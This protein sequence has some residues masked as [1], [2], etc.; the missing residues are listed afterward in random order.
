GTGYSSLSYL[1]QLPVS[2]VK[3]D[4][5]FVT[6]VDGSIADP[7]IVEAV[8][9]LAHTL[10][11]RVVA[12]G[13]EELAQAEALIEFDVDE[14]QGY[15][16]ARPLEA[17]AFVRATVGATWW[18]RPPPRNASA[19]AGGGS[20]AMP[21][22]GGPRDRLLMTRAVDAAPVP[23]VVLDRSHGDDGGGPVIHVNP[24]FERMTGFLSSYLRGHALSELLDSS[25]DH[26]HLTQLLQ[27]FAGSLPSVVRVR[28]RSSWGIPIPVE[29]SATPVDDERG[30]SSQW[31]V[32]VR[33]LRAEAR[34]EHRATPTD[35]PDDEPD[36]RRRDRRQRLAIDVAQRGLD[37]GSADAVSQLADVLAEI[38]AE[39]NVD[40]VY[41]DSFDDASGRAV[42]R[43]E[44]VRVGQPR[45][46]G[47]GPDLGRRAAWLDAIKGS[48]VLVVADAH[49]NDAAWL[50]E[51]FEAFETACR[52]MISVPLRVGGRLLGAMSV[53]MIDRP[54]QWDVDEIGFV[55][56]LAQVI[57]NLLDMR[58]MHEERD[59]SRAQLSAVLEY[60]FDGVAM[61]DPDGLISY[62]NRAGGEL[63]G[64]PV[65]QLVGRSPIEFIEPDDL[66]LAHELFAPDA[67]GPTLG[68]V[69]VRRSD[70]AVIWVELSVTR[71]VGGQLE[72]FVINGR[73][74]T[75]RVLAD[76]AF[77][78]RAGFDELAAGVAQ[79]ALDLGPAAFVERLSEVTAALGRTLRTDRCFVDVVDDGYLR[80]VADWA[81]P[82]HP[83]STFATEPVLLDSLPQWRDHLLGLMPLVVDDTSSPNHVPLD[84]QP[85]ADV[86]NTAYIA[87]PL[88][89]RGQ[90]CG[91]LGVT[92]TSG[93]RIWTHDETALVQALSVTIGSVMLWQRADSLRRDSEER[94]Q[95]LVRI[96]GLTGLANRLAL[97]ERLD[98]IEGQAGE[99]QPVAIMVIDLDQFKNANDRYG[100]DVGDDLLCRLAARFDAIVPEAVCLA[101]TGGDEFAVIGVGLDE[102]AVQALA[103]QIVAAAG[104]PLDADGEQFVVGASVGIAMVPSGGPVRDGL[105]RA[106]RA[107]YEAKHLGGGRA[108]F[109]R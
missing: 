4:R 75:A 62:V 78:R 29:L 102:A 27:S 85:A 22:S 10:G 2:T 83:P 104:A 51:R 91:V 97:R 38:G 94:L 92:M 34:N 55:R 57:A 32:S 87:F 26:A 3:I 14:L 54:H 50:R 109:S 44:Y 28:V 107:M 90:L 25:T 9:R 63:M 13:V 76:A 96:D 1:R 61:L 84:A 31:V 36:N 86:M 82:G 99:R 21:E 68:L 33:D 65:S 105:R 42:H 47:Q 74:V 16:F 100:H 108:Q 43:G 5:S 18:T 17:D 39:L 8:T 20:R 103:D 106:D 30:L 48:H 49:L 71:L 64:V 35:E 40:R 19:D 67:D 66:D 81:R 93:E 101:R 77:A 89:A 73:D 15:Y 12:E 88:T 6:G 72:G 95:R 98:A 79:Q 60:S 11:L 41:V 45:G 7:V 46:E 52:A 70:D 59:R 53:E 58:R 69:R 56:Q 24:A 37:L 23:V 80:N